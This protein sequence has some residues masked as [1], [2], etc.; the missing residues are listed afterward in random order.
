MR[1]ESTLALHHHL[2]NR[3]KDTIIWQSGG[4]RH[5]LTK[6]LL[7]SHANSYAEAIFA[8]HLA[9]I[10]VRLSWL[11]IYMSSEAYRNVAAYLTN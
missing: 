7:A 2:R 5:S 10:D 6:K 3:E 4:E 8:K 1:A 9:A 11:K